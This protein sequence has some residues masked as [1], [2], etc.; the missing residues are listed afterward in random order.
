[1][2]RIG[3]REFI[4]L[5]GGAAAWPIAARAQQAM[6]VVG[7]LEG[8]TNARNRVAVWQGLKEIGY[9]EGG[10]LASEYRTA[11]DQ[12]DRLPSL[13]RELVL[14]QVAVIV[15]S[16]STAAVAAKAATVTIPIVFFTGGDPIE[17]GLVASLNQPGRNVT[18]VARLSHPLVPKRL[19]IVHE[20]VPGT[21]EIVILLHRDNVNT[22]SDS[23]E[24]QAAARSIGK[25]VRVLKVA[26][27]RDIFAAFDS[28]S[29][30]GAIVV[31]PG[32][33]LVQ[34][35]QLL[36]AYAAYRGVPTI[37][38]ERDFVEAGG[39]MSY[40][41]SRLDAHRLV[42]IYTGRILK[43][44]KP[45]DLPVQQSTKVELMINLKTAKALGL[46]V[47]LT[48]LGRADEVVE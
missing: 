12:F 38:P 9:V 23:R 24:F 16:G 17:L 3:R 11:G 18:G 45:A 27:D 13:A 39:L 22:E 44:E 43:G 6:A 10:N 15:A 20:L 47:P 48:L 26:T 37:Y 14:R 5:L 40:D 34:R 8:D 32:S 42:G 19:E 2:L 30:G 46:T 28:I 7:F 31:G 1:M 41:A 4:T 25:Q 33:F 36:I 35:R 21:P 29:P